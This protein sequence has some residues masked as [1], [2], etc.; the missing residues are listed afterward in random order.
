[1]IGFP[2]EKLFFPV[3]ILL[4]HHSITCRWKERKRSSLLLEPKM[5]SNTKYRDSSLANILG[6]SAPWSKITTRMFSCSTTSI[7]GNS[8][9]FTNFCNC[10]ETPHQWHSNRYTPRLTYEVSW[11]RPTLSWW[12]GYSQTRREELRRSSTQ[13]FS[14]RWTTCWG[15]WRPASCPA[16]TK[17]RP[18]TWWQIA[19]KAARWTL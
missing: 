8:I 10:T 9:F 7:L 14:C 13:L 2:L 18:R 4:F 5:A 6:F 16:W 3:R 19:R 1:M 15:D 17:R 11:S 12:R